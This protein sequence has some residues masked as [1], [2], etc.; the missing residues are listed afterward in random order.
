MRHTVAFHAAEQ[1]R[2]IYHVTR[3]VDVQTEIWICTGTDEDE[4]ATGGD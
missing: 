4:F 2:A 3:D 1:L